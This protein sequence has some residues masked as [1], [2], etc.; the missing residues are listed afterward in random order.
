MDR[1]DT[2]HPYNFEM[3]CTQYNGIYKKTKTEWIEKQLQK[4]FDYNID[5]GIVGDKKLKDIKKIEKEK[6]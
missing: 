2:L 1:S 5:Y 3:D 4:Q 6:E